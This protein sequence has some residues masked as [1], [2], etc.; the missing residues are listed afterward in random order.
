MSNLFC[1]DCAQGFSRS[2]SRGP[3][4]KRCPQCAET[5]RKSKYGEQDAR[6]KAKWRE[7][8]LAKC[9]EQARANYVKSRDSRQAYVRQYYKGRPDMRRKHRLGV[10][11]LSPEQHD[12]M[13]ESHAGLCGICKKAPAA[14]SLGRTLNIDHCHATGKVRG[15]LCSK[16]NRGLG[17][18]DDTPSLLRAAADYLEGK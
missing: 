12:R 6:R 14:D 2:G 3:I 15:L 4:P 11:G 5:F 10:Y 8:N 16:C 18:Y 9:S 13:L 17:C 7:E 1:V